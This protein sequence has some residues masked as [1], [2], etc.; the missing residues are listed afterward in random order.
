VIGHPEMKFDQEPAVFIP[1]A[2]PGIDC[3]GTQFRSD[4]SVSLPLQ[5]LRDR[6][7]PTLSD[8]LSAIESS[9]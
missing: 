9:L 6:A 8:V 2:V 3:K 4:S 1:V 5:K 7:L